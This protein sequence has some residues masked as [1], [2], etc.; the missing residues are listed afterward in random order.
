MSEWQLRDVPRICERMIGFSIPN[1]NE[2]LVISYEGTHLLHLDGE[3]TVESDYEFAEYDIYDV[4]AG[5]ARYR[6]R[7]YSVI[8]LHGG[9]PV[10]EGLDDERLMLDATAET[11]TVVCSGR[12]A[13][14]TRF[15]NFSG[16][17][18]AAT[19]STDRHW[20]ALGCPYD[21]DF[22]LFERRCGTP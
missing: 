2:I 17:W 21:F 13:F 20:I 16:D 22:R 1:Q 11:L 5:L 19:F 6:G 4:E 3:I 10:L 12:T 7:D 18:A 14:A 8:G 9:T 15:E